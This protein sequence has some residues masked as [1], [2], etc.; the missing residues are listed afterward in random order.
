[1]ATKS[2]KA[3]VLTSEPVEPSSPAGPMPLYPA[4]ALERF[5][6]LGRD[7]LAAVAKANLAFSQGVQAVSEEIM[8]SAR[9]LYENASQT[10]T[11]LLGAKSLDEVVQLNSDLAKSS[12]E[13]LIEHS[14]KL[15]EMSVSL[16][17]EALA[18]LEGRIEATL[19]TLTKPIAA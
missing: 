3:I 2:K 7:N 12:M 14:A 10:A 6:D 5:A 19:A 4:N 16:A 8:A 11:A 1:M 17:N 15:S 9:S 18:P 13:M